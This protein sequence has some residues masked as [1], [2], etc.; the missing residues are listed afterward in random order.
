MSLLDLVVLSSQGRHDH[1]QELL[2]G[3]LDV[4][5]ESGAHLSGDDDGQTV[6]QQL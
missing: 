3:G 2:E 6:S 1:I 5:G 4:G